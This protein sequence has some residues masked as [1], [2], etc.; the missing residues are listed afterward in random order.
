MKM[1]SEAFAAHLDLEQCSSKSCLACNVIISDDADLCSS[2]ESV[3]K[4][5][6]EV[7]DAHAR[8]ID[9]WDRFWDRHDG[10]FDEEDIC[11]TCGRDRSAGFCLQCHVN[12]VATYKM[13]EEREYVPSD[14]K[15]EQPRRGRFCRLRRWVSKRLGV[16]NRR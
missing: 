13:N 12:E 4:V 2:C 14:E 7:F 11:S 15:S 3:V 6:E 9:E 5:Q 16:A 1:A 8:I 10:L